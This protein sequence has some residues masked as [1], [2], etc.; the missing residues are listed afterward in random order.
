MN[1]A[2]AVRWCFKNLNSWPVS[3]NCSAPSG[4]RWII[5]NL[6]YRDTEYKLVNVD[7]EEIRKGEI[8]NG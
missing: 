8:F 2:A 4:W 7:F 5:S 1:R 6:P 3:I